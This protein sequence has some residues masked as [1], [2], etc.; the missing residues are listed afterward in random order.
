MITFLILQRF[1]HKLIDEHLDTT[2]CSSAQDTA[3][4]KVVRDKVIISLEPYDTSLI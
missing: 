1:T 2:K 3:L 4:L